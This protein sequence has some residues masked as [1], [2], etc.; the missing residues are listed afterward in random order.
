MRFLPSFRAVVLAFLGCLS[1]SLDLWVK[2]KGPTRGGR[3][4]RVALAARP[5]RASE[6]R[7]AMS[8][9]SRNAKIHYFPVLSIGTSTLK[10]KGLARGGRSTR[11]SPRSIALRAG[12]VN[13]DDESDL[14]STQIMHDFPAQS[15]GNLQGRNLR[16]RVRPTPKM[17]A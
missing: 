1:M 11:A 6:V 3:S 5:L 9:T 16:P 17:Y 4:T 15:I 14:S 8:P 7:L 12:G 2:G 13:S 10:N